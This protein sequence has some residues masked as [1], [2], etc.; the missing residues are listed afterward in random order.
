MNEAVTEIVYRQKNAWEQND[1]EAILTDFAPHCVF[2]T[3]KSRYEGIDAVRKVVEGFV[4]TGAKA[5][6]TIHRLMV[7]GNQGAV[8][9]TWQ[10]TRPSSDEIII[11]EDAIILEV[12]EGK[13]IYWREYFNP[14]DMQNE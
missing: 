4:Q 13:I 6:I 1:V 3:P 10:E 14:A 2:I 5:Q 7:D 11:A 12:V 9:W 8:E